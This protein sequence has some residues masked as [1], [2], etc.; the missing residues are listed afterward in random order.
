MGLYAGFWRRA[1]AYVVDSLILLIPSFAITLIVQDP[2]LGLLLEAVM[3]WL[4]SAL[5]ESGEGQATLGKKAFGIKVSDLEGR[6][7]SFVRA[8]GRYFAKFLSGI[9]LGVGFLLAGLTTRKQALHD[10]IAGCLVVRSEAQPEEIAAGGSTMP[11][12]AGVWVVGVLL[13]VVFF[14]GGMLAAIAIPA[15]QDYTIRA[16][17]MNA[18]EAAGPSR[19]APGESPYVQR[20]SGDRASGRIEIFLDT[21]RIGT[22][23]IEQGASIRYVQDGNGWKCS[24]QGVP[25]RYLPRECR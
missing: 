11:M 2:G 19:E 18:I 6:R 15:Y 13:L 22:R 25:A 21:S 20:V 7:I 1:A 8:T 4:Y 3:W 5:M 9:I 24:A 23:L 14:F 10:M 17:V 16:K 12:T